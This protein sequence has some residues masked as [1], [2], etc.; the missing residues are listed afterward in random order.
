MDKIK[1]LIQPWDAPEIWPIR[2]KRLARYLGVRAPFRSGAQNVGFRCAFKEKGAGTVSGMVNSGWVTVRGAGAR[3]LSSS[4]SRNDAQEC[5]MAT[6]GGGGSALPWANR[7][8]PLSDPAS[9]PPLTSL[10][11]DSLAANAHGLTCIRGVDIHLCAALLYRVL[12]RG[13]LDYRLACVFRD[14][15]HADIADA[16]GSLDLLAAMPTHNSMRDR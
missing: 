14:C 6:G 15:G 7:T 8:T 1:D 5:A 16:V 4:S 13:G 11:L 10:A 12:Q 2:C 9:V 3:A